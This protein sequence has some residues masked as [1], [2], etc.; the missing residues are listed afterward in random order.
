M[1]APEPAP[2]FTP[3]LDTL[4]LTELTHTHNNN[5]TVDASFETAL[6]TPA[7][8][9]TTAS[10]WSTSSSRFAVESPDSGHREMSSDS[11]VLSSTPSS[12]ATVAR[13]TAVPAT[14][15]DT[16]YLD[17]S[18]TS[19]INGHASLLESA[20]SDVSA[21]TD[22]SASFRSRHSSDNAASFRVEEVAPHQDY[23]VNG[24]DVMSKMTADSA[25]KQAA[26]KPSTAHAPQRAH[27]ATSHDKPS[28]QLMTSSA[29]GGGSKPS[30]LNAFGYHPDFNMNRGSRAP[31]ATTGQGQGQSA[32]RSESLSISAEKRLDPFRIGGATADFKASKS[33]SSLQ[34]NVQSALAA[35]GETDA[36]AGEV[37]ASADAAAAAR[38]DDVL[39]TLNLNLR[40]LNTS[41]KRHSSTSVEM[42]SSATGARGERAAMQSSSESKLMMRKQ[43]SKLDSK[44]DGIFKMATSP[45][46]AVK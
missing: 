38:R 42:T 37:E 8:S 23:E 43:R 4:D 44:S 34:Q 30:P 15:A 39:K 26:L 16:S 22:R 25:Q 2:S 40:S 24:N 5:N 21:R 6:S 7:T 33:A 10:T 1:T 32:S 27:S 12:D 20:T 19:S 36:R 35:N 45:M 3:G 9:M 41:H 46:E 13:V 29:Y 17:V 11:L 14:S 18:V 31:L 28:T